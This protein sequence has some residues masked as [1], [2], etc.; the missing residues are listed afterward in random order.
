MSPLRLS[1]SITSCSHHHPFTHGK[2]KKLFC[3][4]LLDETLTYICAFR[5]ITHYT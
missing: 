4:V 2:M 3:H 5:L 1:M